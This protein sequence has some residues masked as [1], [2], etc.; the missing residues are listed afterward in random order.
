[1]MKTVLKE[2]CKVIMTEAKEEKGGWPPPCVG[3]A[4]QPKRPDKRNDRRGE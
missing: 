3:Y 4:Y 1:M 2:I